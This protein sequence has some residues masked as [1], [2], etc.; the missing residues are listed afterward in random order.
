MTIIPKTK[1]RKYGMNEAL[2]LAIFQHFSFGPPP[3]GNYKK[4]NEGTL[5]SEFSCVIFSNNHG[6]YVQDLQKRLLIFSLSLFQRHIEIVR[7]WVS[8]VFKEIELA[9]FFYSFVIYVRR[10]SGKK[11]LK[12]N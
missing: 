2:V 10:D 11:P 1:G 6:K 3:P 5:A 9:V 12:I 7:N 4:N 8:R